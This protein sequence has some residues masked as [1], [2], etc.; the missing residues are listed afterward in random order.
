M[1]LKKKKKKKK[2]K[3]KKKDVREAKATELQTI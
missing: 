1:K 2:E 3:R